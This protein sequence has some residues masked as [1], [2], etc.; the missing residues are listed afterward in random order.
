MITNLRFTDSFAR[1]LLMGEGLA[2]LTVA[3][4]SVTI[5]KFIL[6]LK[7]AGLDPCTVDTEN[8]IAFLFSRSDQ[9][10]TGKTVSRDRAALRSFFRYLNTE[11]LRSD[12]PADLL[13]SPRR[14]QIL[15]RVL[16]AEQ[17]E[18]FLAGIDVSTVNGFRDRVLFELIYSCGLRV[19]EAVHLSIKDI[20]LQE[21]VIIV[22]GKGKRERI[23]PFGETAAR[24]LSQWLSIERRKMIKKTATQAVFLNSRGTRLTRKGIWKRFQAICQTAGVYAKVHSLRHSFATHLLEGGADLRTVQQLLGHADVSTTQIYTHVGNDGLELYHR[25]YFPAGQA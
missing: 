25:D 8:C 10:L 13:E 14:E 6:W 2:E 22:S 23:V 3:T 21:R 20:H 12:N 16:N 11:G 7:A 19:S 18:L 17:I 4:Y 1:F 9:G 5:R 15:P 24:W